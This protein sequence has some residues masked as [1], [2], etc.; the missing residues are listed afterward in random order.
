MQQPFSCCNKIYHKLRREGGT[1][2]LATIFKMKVEEFIEE[3]NLNKYKKAI[4]LWL[5]K[6]N[7]SAAKEICNKTEVPYGKIYETLNEMEKQGLISIIPSEPKTYK[8]LNPKIAFKFM[9]E[10]QKESINQ[11][12]KKIDLL[13]KVEKIKKQNLDTE[14]LVLKGRD[15][16]MAMMKSMIERT[17][18]EFCLIPGK[19]TEPPMAIRLAFV[20]ILKNN[21]KIKI[22]LRKKSN[23]NE[24]YIKERTDL[25][26]EIKF[27]ILKGLRLSIKDDDEILLSIVD[28]DS[29]DRISIYTTNKLFAHS[30]KQLFNSLWK[31]RKKF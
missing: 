17:K 20:R 12:I 25:G 31:N 19:L 8:A 15:K 13:E 16:Y 21:K 7:N 5:L 4:Y 14:L 22:I 6:T 9:L 3:L 11:K 26:A 18:N 10:K 30:M 28:P 27:N 1:N 23:E 24:D 2:T 29:K